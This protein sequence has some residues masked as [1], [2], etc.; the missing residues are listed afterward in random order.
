MSST[1]VNVFPYSFMMFTLKLM[2]FRYDCLMWFVK[3]CLLK[4]KS[5]VSGI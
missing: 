5:L 2:M 4:I 3:H 1:I